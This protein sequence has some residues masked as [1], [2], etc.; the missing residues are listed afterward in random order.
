MMKNLVKMI[1]VTA[2]V[3]IIALIFSGPA[4]AADNASATVTYAVSGINE[5]A[6]SGSPGAMTISTATAGS[7]PDPVEDATTTYAFTTN[8]T[9]RKITG[10]LSANMPS[11]LTLEVNLAAAGAP[12]AWSST[13]Y[14]SL[15]TSAADLATGGRKR[16]SGLTIT[17]RLSATVDAGEVSSGTTNVTYTLTSQ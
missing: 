12:N 1:K 5:I 17:Y 8:Q 16:A 2:A 3:A 7:E 9:T 6:V 11:G 13:G 4:F 14:Q 10:A 15:S